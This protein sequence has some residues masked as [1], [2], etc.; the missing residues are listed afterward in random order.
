[1]KIERNQILAIVGP[2][3]SGK[4]QLAMQ[5]AQQLQ[6]EIVIC[7]AFQIREG[8]P[9]LTT[10]PTLEEQEAVPHHLLSALPLTQA[11]TAATFV[12]LADEA[13][14]D[15]QNRNKVVILCGGTGL[16]LQALLHGLF[17][18]PGASEEIRKNLRREAESLGLAS[19]HL[20][21]QQVDPV[22]AQRIAPTDYVRIERALEVFLLTNRPISDWH[23]ESQT[24]PLRYKA[25]QIGLDPGLEGV[26]ARIGQRTEDMLV[27]GVIEEA[28]SVYAQHPTL[29]HPPLGYEVL[30]QYVRGQTTLTEMK[31]SL[32]H[33]TAHY[34]KRQRTWFRKDK[35]IHWFVDVNAAMQYVRQSEILTDK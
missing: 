10:K 35:N 27:Q 2:T 18:G 11:S 32:F 19:L 5:M 34:A 3:A 7:D 16:Y 13:I 12:R 21:L 30:L 24:Q 20:R 9:I 31:Q 22:A 25:F 17:P 33:Q 15:I 14:A 8:L 26:R 28:K 29:H 6:G 23:K 4:T 1:M